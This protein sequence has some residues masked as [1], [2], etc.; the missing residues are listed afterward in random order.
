VTWQA[1]YTG[2]STGGVTTITLAYEVGYI[3]YLNTAY[4]GEGNKLEIIRDS[5]VQSTYNFYEVDECKY[6]PVNCDFVNKHGEWQRIVFFKSSVSN[7]EMN[8]NEYNLMPSSTNYNIKDN[9]RQAFNINGNDKITVNTGWVFESYSDTITQLMLSEK[10]LLDDVP[11]LVTTKSIDKQTG[12]NNKNIN[13][14]L[15]FKNSAP[16]LNYNT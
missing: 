9:V 7:F 12:L 2:L 10:I 16:K 11:M 1:R 3:P 15:E 14:K 13:Y 4:I 8:S 5:V 6:T